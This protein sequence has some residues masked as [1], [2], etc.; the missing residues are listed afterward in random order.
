MSSITISTS[1]SDY[2]DKLEKDLSIKLSI[3][4][5]RW[6]CHQQSI[7][8]EKIR[9][10]Y[11]ST[12]AEAFISSSDAYYFQLYIEEAYKSNRCLSSS[13]YDQMEPVYCSMDIGVNDL[14]VI[15]F[16]QVIHGEIRLIDYYEDKNKGVDFY[17]KYLLQDKPYIYNTIFLPHD[18]AKRDGI[19][20]ENS[21]ERDF[22][23]LFA[24]TTTKFI[25]LKRTD[26]NINI[27]NAKSKFSRC[28]FNI[29]KTKP[30][31]DQLAKYRK[32]WSEQFG[33]YLDE[34]LH[35]ISSNYADS[36]IYACQAVSH[37]ETVGSL[38]GAMEKHKEAV[39]SRIGKI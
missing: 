30:L 35:D 18:A 3:G 11:P 22:K 24:H 1:Q 17:A 4:Q 36:F 27:A 12:V 13:L 21:Y 14:T 39:A 16:F 32:K 2:F 38:K 26:K 20:V 37:L 19:I 6:Y 15:T 29:I 7:L 8:G 5:R 33:K 23:R 9:Q 28:V 34:P 25:V 31:L 10:E